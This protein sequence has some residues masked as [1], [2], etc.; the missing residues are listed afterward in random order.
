MGYRRRLE[1]KHPI[2]DLRLITLRGRIL[3]KA[4]EH[5]H[6]DPLSPPERT[7]CPMDQKITRYTRLFQDKSLLDTISMLKIAL[8]VT[9]LTLL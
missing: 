1:R 7:H 8:I 5:H 2:K 6:S 4:I 9:V 3:E